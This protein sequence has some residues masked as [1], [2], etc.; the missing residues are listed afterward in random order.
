MTIS[1]T[2]FPQ[3]IFVEMQLGINL[4]DFGQGNLMGGVLIMQFFA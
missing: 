2:L 3:S 4:Q 1:G